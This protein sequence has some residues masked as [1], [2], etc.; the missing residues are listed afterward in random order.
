MLGG[1]NRRAIYVVSGVLL[2]TLVLTVGSILTYAFIVPE[3]EK[4]KDRNSL[5]I[6]R[7][8][9]REMETQIRELLAKGPGSSNIFEINLP[10]GELRID[11]KKDKVTYSIRTRVSYDPGSTSRLNVSVGENNVLTMWSNL[12]VDLE[13]MYT[14]IDPGR[15]TVVMR[16]EEEVRMV[17]DE[18]TLEKNMTGPSV[19][20]RTSNHYTSMLDE[21]IEGID[22]DGDAD[23]ADRWLLYLSDPNEDYVFDTFAIHDSDGNPISKL[24][25]LE[26]GD[27]FRLEGTP[28]TVFRVRERYVVLRYARIRMEVKG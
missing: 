23:T 14:R 17:I 12:T 9:L 15:H 22:L 7:N 8:G 16:F 26:E 1:G 19:A 2:M 11:P 6:V 13:T 25:E 3:I 28:L 18:W 10:E 5:D 20:S 27:S 21:S 4:G 24:E